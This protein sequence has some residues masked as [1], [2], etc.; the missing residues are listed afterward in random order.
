VG[1]SWGG[2]LA[3]LRGR[4]LKIVPICP[5]VRAYLQRHPEYGDLVVE[6]AR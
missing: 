3:D 4:G 5:F 1:S 2:A 6:R